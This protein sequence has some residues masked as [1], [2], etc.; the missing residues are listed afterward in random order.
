M[1]ADAANMITA[2]GLEDLEA[3]LATAGGGWS[4]RDRRAHQNRS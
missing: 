3:E 4:A 2:E 1:S